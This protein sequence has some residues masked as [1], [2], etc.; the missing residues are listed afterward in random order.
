[1]KKMATRQTVGAL[2][3]AARERSPLCEGD[4]R[5]ETVRFARTPSNRTR[6]LQMA[7]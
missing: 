1:M 6:T 7:F 5:F 2:Y 3:S 4:F